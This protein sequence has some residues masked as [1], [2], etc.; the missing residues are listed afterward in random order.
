MDNVMFVMA[1][2]FIRLRN[3]RLFIYLQQIA[4]A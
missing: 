1:I 3:I 2:Y 4:L